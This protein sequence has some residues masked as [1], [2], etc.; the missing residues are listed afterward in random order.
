MSGSQF[1]KI[2]TFQARSYSLCENVLKDNANLSTLCQRFS[3]DGPRPT[4]GSRRSFKWAAKRSATNYFFGFFWKDF[5]GKNYE[6]EKLK[7]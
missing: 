4:D 5:F 6:L 7:M 1:K 2:I 3:T